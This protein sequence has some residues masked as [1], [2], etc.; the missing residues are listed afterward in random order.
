[1]MIRTSVLAALEGRSIAYVNIFLF[2]IYFT[3][4]IIGG[5]VFM[6]L[7]KPEE[8]RVCRQLNEEY[9]LLNDLQ[10]EGDFI[11]GT[12]RSIF[13]ILDFLGATF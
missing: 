12:S 2:M 10:K 3:Y 11:I 6:W 9:K 8:E 7:E 1:M 4:I 5:V 13:L